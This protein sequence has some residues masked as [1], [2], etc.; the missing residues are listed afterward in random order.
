MLA[1]KPVLVQIEALESNQVAHFPR[2]GAFMSGEGYGGTTT[3]GYETNAPGRQTVQQRE[4]S[5]IEGGPKMRG[6]K[7]QRTQ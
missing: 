3:Y 2:D 1:F 6:S 4:H 7:R 5:L